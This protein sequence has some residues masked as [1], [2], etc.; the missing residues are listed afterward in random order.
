MVKNKSCSTVY[1]RQSLDNGSGK[2]HVP[3]NYGAGGTDND[4]VVMYGHH[5]I[6]QQDI[7]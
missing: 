1:S 6:V 4:S 3:S 7:N 5:M 2:I